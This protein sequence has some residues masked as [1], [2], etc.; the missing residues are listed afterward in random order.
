MASGPTRVV[1]D[2]NIVLSA[3]LFAQGRLPPLRSAWR[4]ARF[5]PLVCTATTKELVRAL[6]YPKFRLS[7]AEQRERGP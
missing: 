6:S 2:T 4:E 7:A 3:L 5:Q 1:L